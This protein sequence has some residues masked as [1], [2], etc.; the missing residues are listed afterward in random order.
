MI[1]VEKHIINE[2][3]SFF[4]E[5]DILC[6]KSKN[7]Y[8]QG[9]YNVRQYYFENKKYLNYN[10]NFHVTKTQESYKE[11]PRKI[12]NQ[13]LKLV[14]RNFKSF[15]SLL[16]NES[17]KNKIPHYLDKENGRYVTIFEKQALGLK[18]FKKT[19]CIHLSQTNIKIQTKILDFNIIK[20]VRIVPRGDHYIIEVVYEK[21]CKINNNTRIAAVDPGLNNLATI[22][23]NDGKQP[24]IINGKPLKSINQYYNKEKA[25]LQSILEKQ[26]GRKTSKKIKKLTYKRNNKI[27]DYLHKVSRI[28]VNQ[29]V[30]EHV[31]TIVLGKNIGQKQ[32]SNIGKVNNQN[33]VG[34]PTFRFLDMIKYKCE[35]EGINVI[36]QEE[37]YTSKASFLN[38]DFIPIY[39]N[40]NEDHK[41]SGTRIKR[42]LYK[43]NDGK[44]INADVNGSYNILRK[45]IPNAF[46]DGIEG[47]AVYPI[48]LN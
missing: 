12:S 29:L 34:I 46:A 21:E 31:G 36:W 4:N 47:V 9:L 39:G 17:V 16:N 45:A 15:F 26:Y 3:H 19:G 44:L 43:T 10:N 40:N 2:N 41:F 25:E 5:C 14:D 1:L 24:Y 32:D 23:F 18:E 38:S 33:F 30:S 28:L 11:L 35:L 37:S 42:G 13:T 8:N 22:T 20:E 48:R 27:N 6:F 7:V